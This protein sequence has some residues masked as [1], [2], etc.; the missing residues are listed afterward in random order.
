LF[1]TVLDAHLVLGNLPED[2]HDTNTA[3]GRPAT[4][5][6]ARDR[7]ARMI[8]ADRESF[9]VDDAFQAAQAI[10]AAQRRLIGNE[11]RRVLDRVSET[12]QMI[13][14][15]GQGEFLARQVLDEL[16]IAGRR[17]SL[18]EQLGASVSQSAA[19]YSVAVLAEEFCQSQRRIQ[20][21]AVVP[22]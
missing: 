22:T 11:L 1:S 20:T 7:L 3:D 6:A 13:L 16:R 21:C 2:E 5:S 8:G 12:P 10:A 18:G 9:D 17:L 19:A 4:C 14:V 15:S